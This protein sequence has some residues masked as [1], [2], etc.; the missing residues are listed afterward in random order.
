MAKTFVLHDESVNTRGFRMLTSGANLEEFIKNP[1]MLLNHNDWAMPIGR[2][3]NIRKEGGKILA[4]AVFDEADERAR[5]VSRKVEG[6]FIRMAS[7]GAWPPE[8]T[9]DAFDLM[10]H[11]QSLPTVTKWT[12]REASIV[13][14]G[15]NHNALCFYDRQSKQP[16]SLKDE[17]DVIRLM[18][19]TNHKNSNKMNILASVLKLSDGATEADCV[20]AVQRIIS[21]NDRLKQENV[22]LKDAVDKASRERKENEKKQAI[23]LVDTAVKEGR[24]DATGKNTYLALFDKDFA[25]ASA[26]LAAI[27]KRAGVAA[28]IAGASQSV[29]LG[30]WK[31]KTWEELDKADKLVELRDQF[32]DLYDQKFEQ[33][34]GVKP[35][36]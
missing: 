16:I 8:E 20:S 25:S 12:V 27:P 24:I 21:D 34:F 22:T 7:I 28:Q 29:D 4:D 19:N 3:E 17:K 14:I 11:G 30:D 13:T 33:R 2:W 10:I 9:S 15:S 26:A 32:P 31:N 6:N 35:K 1:V 5:E 36:K 23:V 18:D